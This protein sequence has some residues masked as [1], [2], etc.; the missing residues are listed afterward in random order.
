MA[1][2][3]A[4][5][6]RRGV[7]SL[8][9][10]G[11]SL[12]GG[13]GLASA[14]FLMT[15]GVCFPSFASVTSRSLAAATCAGVTSMTRL[16]M[17]ASR[18]T[19]TSSFEGTQ[20]GRSLRICKP[21]RASRRTLRAHNVARFWTLDNNWTRQITIRIGALTISQLLWSTRRDSQG[22]A[23]AEPYTNRGP[24]TVRQVTT[25]AWPMRLGGESGP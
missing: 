5:A 13:T 18:E 24:D 6:L 4:R 11:Q 20:P 25:S 8:R 14:I 15:G 1:T 9:R 16:A 21:N 22:G 2:D 12:G 19:I 23:C 10:P 7:R 3:Q 17:S